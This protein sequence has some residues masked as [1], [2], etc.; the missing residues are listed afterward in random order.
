MRVIVP[1]PP[2]EEFGGFAVE[3][4][5]PKVDALR[6]LG[7]NVELVTW[8]EWVDQRRRREVMSRLKD[9][10]A[11]CV[12][13]P[14]AGYGLYFKDDRG[15]NLF[16]DVLGLPTL[17]PWDHMLTQAPN[18]FLG[19]QRYVSPQQPGA[20]ATIKRGLSS[21]LFKHYAM[22]TGHTK[23]YEDLA[24]L[25]KGQVRGYA[26]PVAQQFVQ[27]GQ[28]ETAPNAKSRVAFGGNLYVSMT[29]T[30]PTLQNELVK[31][32]NAALISTKAQHWDIAAWDLFCAALETLPHDFR[33]QS[34]LTT[35]HP[36]FWRLAEDLLSYSVSTAMR[37][38]VLNAIDQPI[39]FY[40]NF[41]DPDSTASLPHHVRFCGTADYVNELPRVYRSYEIWIDV[42]NAAFIKGH[43]GKCY[44]CFAA[45]SF[46]LVDYHEDLRAELGEIA[47]RFMYRNLDDLTE[48]L[49]YYLSHATERREIVVAVQDIIRARLTMK[50]MCER[51]CADMAAEPRVSSPDSIP[52][53]GAPQRQG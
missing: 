43:G 45:G 52:A 46:M 35:D 24:L 9:F 21:P 7:V 48:K 47:D 11:Q 20:L 16:T 17:L 23:V 32:L 6:E 33:L 26:P 4:A 14:Q 30:L 44:G 8:E 3:L 36:L 27:A 40:G 22:D 53:G 28:A 31:Q 51:F 10:H 5:R 12:I 18:Y 41:N 1:L 15:E 37:L 49:A 25:S 42:V 39:D 34:G 2:Q 29:A 50:N 38:S 19:Q 13:A